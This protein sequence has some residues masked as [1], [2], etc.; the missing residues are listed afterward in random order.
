MLTD[1]VR[2]R[3][4]RRDRPAPQA[5]RRAKRRRSPTSSSARVPRRSPACSAT[6]RSCSPRTRSSGP[7]SR[8]TPR[9]SRTPSRSCC[10]SKRRRRCRAAGRR[11]TSSCT[12]RSC[13]R[14]RRC[15]CSPARPGATNAST[16]IADRFDIHRPIDHH[17]AF[18]YGI[19]FC[20]GAALARL[21]GRIGIEETLRAV[22]HLG[23]RPRPRRAP[24]HQHRARLQPAADRGG[25]VVNG[26]PG[27]GRATPEM[28]PAPPRGRTTG[29]NVLVIVLDDLGFAQLG[30][31]G[32][33]IAT[34]NIDALAAGGLRFN[35]FHVTALCSPTRAALLT[36]RNHHA[37]GMGMLPELAVRYE[38]YNGRIPPRRRD[39][40]R[41]TCATTATRPTPSASGTW[42]RATNGARR[43]RSTAGRSGSASNASTAS[44]VATRTSGRRS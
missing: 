12:A 37:V 11:V 35:R 4:H 25:R 17:V 19:H 6:R 24:A 30:C 44:S 31:F 14:T 3:D 34:P 39:A 9:S 5:D 2:R 29:P 8:P 23:S 41:G 10:G 40:R 27:N 20:L 42:R 7:S 38:G 43:V 26:S 32:S 1:L 22:P 21:E 36:G 16:R 18:G 28:M 15:C 13:P 33:D